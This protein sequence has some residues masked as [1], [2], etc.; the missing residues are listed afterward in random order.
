VT[1]VEAIKL[2]G[3]IAGLLTAA[4]MVWDRFLRGRPLAEVTAEKRFS[5]PEE[6]I[7]I[8]NPGPGDVLIREVRVHQ[9]AP[10]IYEIAKDHSARAIISSLYGTDVSV[11]LRPGEE[12]LL[13][14]I[15]RPR[16]IDRPIDMSSRRVWF[17]IYWRKTSLT[18]LPQPPV[19]V[20]TSSDYIKR[21]AA[22][23]TR[24]D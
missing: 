5:N 16:D 14:I 1:L 10:P 19:F 3:G 8:K 7:R 24:K 11:L 15:E 9:K 20:M 17:F 22:A 21:I 2:F 6:Y 18:W 13:P 12:R 4:F 23:A